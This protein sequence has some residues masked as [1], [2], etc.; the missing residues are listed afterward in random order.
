[1]KYK[2]VIHSEVERV[3]QVFETVNAH[4]VNDEIVTEKVNRGWFVHFEGSRELIFFGME[5]PQLYKGDKI[6]ITF[7]RMPN[8]LAASPSK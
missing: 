1:M 4:K 5:K 8:D 2:Y 3:E 7:E 6:K